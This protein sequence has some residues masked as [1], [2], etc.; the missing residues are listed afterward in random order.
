MKGFIGIIFDWLVA[1]LVVFVVLAVLKLM[2]ALGMAWV[3]LLLF[4]PVG[5]AAIFAVMVVVIW[6]V[7]KIVDE[8]ED[9][10]WNLK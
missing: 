9:R 4:V 1:T 10:R 3:A 8:V 5:M 2:G 7:C 6:Y